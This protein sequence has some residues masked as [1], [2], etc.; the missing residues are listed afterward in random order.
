MKSILWYENIDEKMHLDPV[1][2]AYDYMK[3]TG[4]VSDERLRRLDPAFA[5]TARAYGLCTPP[6]LTA[7]I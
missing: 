3:R 2:F 5:D 6:E 7:S 1:P 4:R